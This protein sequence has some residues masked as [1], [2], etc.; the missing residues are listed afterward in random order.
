MKRLASKT[1]QIGIVINSKKKWIFPI[2]ANFKREN[3]RKPMEYNTCLRNPS[4][5][6][7][8]HLRTTENA[9]WCLKPA[10]GGQETSFYMLGAKP[11]NTGG[12]VQAV[13]S[14]NHATAETTESQARA[15]WRLEE[16]PTPPHLGTKRRRR[17][18]AAGRGPGAAGQ[19]PRCK[20]PSTRAQGA[21]PRGRSGPQAQAGRPPAGV[22]LPPP[23]PAVRGPLPSAARP[24]QD[25]SQRPAA[26]YTAAMWPGKRPGS[27][28][29]FPLPA[30]KS[31]RLDFTGKAARGIWD[32]GFVARLVSFLS[33][34]SGRPLLR[35]SGKLQLP[36]HLERGQAS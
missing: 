23:V 2:C 7:F 14:K 32:S 11:W 25:P 17:A 9:V 27:S 18:G 29:L 5:G 21:G 12:G 35:P 13:C 22:A 28:S 20:G 19:A 10:D 36:A 3:N 33:L 1:A 34:S 6:D 8:L 16:A 31:A 4:L 15:G 30:I 26:I 24:G